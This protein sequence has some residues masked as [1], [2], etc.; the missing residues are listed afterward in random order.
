[1]EDI[2]S[3]LKK[4]ERY[5]YM[6]LV[7]D[8]VLNQFYIPFSEKC[9]ELKAFSRVQC[10]GSP[11]DLITAYAHVDVPETE[12]MLYE[13]NFSKIAAS[14]AALSSKNAVS[15]ET[16]TCLY[17]W[18]DAYHLEEQT[19]DLKLVADALFA[20]GTSQ[21]IW[22]GMPF[23]PVGEDSQY[24]YATVHVGTKGALTE[25]IPA[26]NTYMTKVSKI[27]RKGETY[28]DVAVY[29]PLE[30]SWIA[31]EYP[32]ELQME[33]SWGAYE[34]RYIHTPEELKGY[35]PLWIN[36][37]FLQNAALK[38]NCLVCGDT[39]FTSLY[40]DVDFLDSEALDTI[41]QLAEQGFPICMRRKPKEPGRKKS[42]TYQSRLN[43]LLNLPNV[44]E[45]F[46]DIAVNLPLVEGEDIPDFWCR[47]DKEGYYLFFSHPKAKNLTYPLSYGQS[48]TEKTIEVPIHIHTNGKTKEFLLRFE[49]YQSILLHID[50]DGLIS[51][52]DI[53]FR[54]K[55]PLL[56]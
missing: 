7:A 32:E 23:N 5:D 50:G 21:I 4:D 30:D 39:C 3:D 52:I 35:H 13:P 10:A 38:D 12:A 17:G 22:H 49:P 24:F 40:V 2:Y 55:T 56:Q 33:W 47:K 16:F 44:S 29:L 42:G 1:M 45:N 19:A 25:E 11:T 15:A 53:L 46:G 27:M 31:G 8:F 18:P 9:H 34:L 6:K 48:Y 20:H 43:D 41:R 28:S 36:H 14:A 51:P 54:P 26:F 37:H